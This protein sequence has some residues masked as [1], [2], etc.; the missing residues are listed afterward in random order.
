MFDVHWLFSDGYVICCGCCV[1]VDRATLEK[2]MQEL[3]LDMTDKDDVRNPLVHLAVDV[4]CMLNLCVFVILKNSTD[5]S[6]QILI[7]RN[8]FL[9]FI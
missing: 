5:T 9:S 8:F 4:K 2:N 1:Q 7:L 3:G 6:D